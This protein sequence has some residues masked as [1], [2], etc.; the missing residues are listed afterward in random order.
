[1]RLKTRGF[2]EE[3]E[4]KNSDK[5]PKDTYHDSKYEEYVRSTVTYVEL[6]GR[7]KVSLG[8]SQIPFEQ[9][10]AGSRKT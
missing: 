1:M 9:E 2:E 8:E 7:R 10:G 3:V 6:L 4:S 5:D